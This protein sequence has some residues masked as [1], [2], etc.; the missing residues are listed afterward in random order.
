MSE[1][2]RG[3]R[4]VSSAIG[5]Q[6]MVEFQYGLLRRLKPTAITKYFKRKKDESS[7]QHEAENTEAQSSDRTTQPSE[8]NGKAT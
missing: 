3:L 6:R 5:L 2:R 8:K 1:V 4:S 7:D